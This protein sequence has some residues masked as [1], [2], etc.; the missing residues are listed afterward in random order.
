MKGE[1]V[2]KNWFTDI[3][4]HTQFFK[5]FFITKLLITLS[6]YYNKKYE[7]TKNNDRIQLFR[8]NRRKILENKLKQQV[9]YGN[10]MEE[11]Y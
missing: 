7:W 5:T 3:L 1:D 6:I 2:M 9:F 8:K 11:L 4:V 10:N